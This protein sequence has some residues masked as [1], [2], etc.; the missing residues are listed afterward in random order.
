MYRD[1]GSCSSGNAT[2]PVFLSSWMRLLNRTDP[3]V[4]G[5]KP[6]SLSILHPAVALQ[7]GLDV[8][9]N[10]WYCILPFATSSG[11]VERAEG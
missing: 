4:V 7:I 3:L 9:S 8:A 1:A 5:R 6:F 2:L 10:F 11:G